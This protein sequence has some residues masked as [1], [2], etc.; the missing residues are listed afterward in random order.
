MADRTHYET[1]GIE[2]RATAEQIRRAYRDLAKQHHP[3][4]G[5]KGGEK[6]FAA[7]A[8]AYEVLSDSAKRREYD[9]LLD[10]QRA[11]RAG[12][13]GRGPHYSWENIASA[14][15]SPRR[16]VAEFDELY[17][18]FYGKHERRGDGGV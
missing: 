12:H 9:L 10:Q 15:T 8:A 16:D 7:I 3:D 6:K 17:D 5:V 1:L 2:P 14:R 11:E 13:G 4:T 18:T